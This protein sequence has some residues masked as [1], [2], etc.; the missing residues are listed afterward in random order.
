MMSSWRVMLVDDH[1]L[2]RR[3]LAALFA[4]G[5][6]LPSGGGGRR[7][8]GGIATAEK[9]TVDVVILDLSMPRLNGLETIKR[10]VKKFPRTKTMVLSMHEDEQFVARALQDGAR[11]YV[12]KHAMDDE[13]FKALDAILRGGNL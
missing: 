4:I 5:R 8:R 12:L 7:W 13:L 1:K 10:I 11:G 2:V 6:P 3:G 9:T